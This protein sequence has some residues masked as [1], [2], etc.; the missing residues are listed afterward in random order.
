MSGTSRLDLGVVM[1]PPDADRAFDLAACASAAE[2]AGADSLWVD[3]H[4]VRIEGAN[5]PYP[6]SQDGQPTWAPTQPQLEALTA[7]AFMAAATDR[8]SIGTAVLILPQRPI[9]ELAKATATLDVLSGGRLVLGCGV[10]WLAEEMEACGW[11]FGTRG[12]RADEMLQALRHCWTGR[13]PEIVGKHVQLPPGLVFRPTPVQEPGPPVLV[14]GMSGPAR[15]RAARHGDGWLAFVPEELLDLEDL[16]NQLADV[17]SRRADGPRARDR[18]RRSVVYGG[19]P[20]DRDVLIAR[21]L[22]LAQLGFDELIV[23]AD[24]AEPEDCIRAIQD[25]RGAL[26][27]A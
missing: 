3:D 11:E 13:P 4:L 25:L 14:G 23:E 27:S 15:R 1:A 24:W 16:A 20:R 7:L 12:A 21:L 9:I 2:T 17:D 22:A 10:G 8:C 6:F 18:F 26:D 19:W 5:S